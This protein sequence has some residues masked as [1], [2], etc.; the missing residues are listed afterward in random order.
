MSLKKTH[1]CDQYSLGESTPYRT[2]VRVE[3][4]EGVVEDV[5]AVG[6]VDAVGA[7]GAVSRIVTAF[8]CDDAPFPFHVRIIPRGCR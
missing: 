8:L 1:V 7:V 6:A 3:G 4:G 5:G 2:R